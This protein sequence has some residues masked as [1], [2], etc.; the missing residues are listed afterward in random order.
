MVKGMTVDTN[1]LQK[2]IERHKE[3]AHFSVGEIALRSAVSAIPYAGGPILELWSGV[4]QR[5]VHER[6]N[7]VF[8]EMKERLDTV[9]A[10]KV[11]RAFFDSEEFQTLLYLLI[12]KLHTTHEQAKLKMFGD[13]LANSGNMEFKVDDKEIFIRALRDLSVKD[14]E[15]LSD[16]KLKGWNPLT[17]RIEYGPEILSSLSRLSGFGLVIEKFLRPNPNT[18]AEQQLQS[19]L[20]SPPWRT[21]Q[22]TTLGERFLQFVATPHE[23]GG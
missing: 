14:I 2:S 8:A 19:L 10:E 23:F 20:S 9:N 15:T 7:T 4:A 22:I 16:E 1:E 11:N 12:E 6:L 21:F 13:A 18:S 5:R 3:A 17:K